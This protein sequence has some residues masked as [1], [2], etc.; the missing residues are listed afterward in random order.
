LN[1]AALSSGL[2]NGATLTTSGSNSTLTLGVADAFNAGFMSTSNQT[3]GGTKTFNNDIIVSG[4]KFGGTLNTSNAYIGFGA[5][6]SLSTGYDNYAI[7]FNALNANTSGRWNVSI[8]SN[9]LSSNTTGYWN[10]AVGDNALRNGI[11]SSGN[12]GVGNYAL[13]VST[14]SYNTA[15]GSG[16]LSLLTSG[17]YN[18]AIGASSS[19]TITSTQSIFIGYGA[20]AA[21][22]NSTNETVI[23]YNING[24]GNNTTSIGNTNT[25]LARLYGDLLLSSNNGPISDAGNYPLQVVGNTLTSGS[26]YANT[27][28]STV[29][30]GNAP[31][32]VSSTTP[33]ANL[34]IGGTATALS[35]ATNYVQASGPNPIIVS[36]ANSFPSSVVSAII[37]TNG[38][39]VQITL[40]GDLKVQ[41][42][43]EYC[44]IRL[45]RDNIAL[46]TDVM[47]KNL[48]TD[49]ASAP[50]SL[51]YIDNPV[52]G[53]YTYYLKVTS[54]GGPPGTLSFGATS[55]P[56]IT[57]LEL[58]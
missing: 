54:A 49:G 14:G 25:T 19:G 57:L 45:Y 58:R 41:Y 48:T 26:A 44:S 33:V 34:N 27:F 3:F 4:L 36:T 1:L 51:N 16:S 31:F 22:T 5:L 32:A 28:V 18:V 6:S 10:T 43:N 30:T 35:T 42:A 37:N 56:T 50:F 15:V 29:A 53:S 2:T 40:Y 47:I 46:G 55:A 11:T 21:S 7:G 24:L 17:S 52:A 38:R 20:A 13:N 12:T 9:T 23:G 39:P 8:G